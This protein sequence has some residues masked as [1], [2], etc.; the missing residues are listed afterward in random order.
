MPHI[1]RAAA[2]TATVWQTQGFVP[3]EDEAIRK[4]VADYQ[5]ASGNKL[6]LTI[7]PFLALMQKTVSALTTGDVPDVVSMDAP[8]TLLSQNA[9]DDKLLD[10]SDV[11]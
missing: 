10:V 9:W 2:T 3:A 7:T 5:K 4:V 11:V 6:E 8:D 1:A